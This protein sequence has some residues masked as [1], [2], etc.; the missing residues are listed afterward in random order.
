[1]NFLDL[2]PLQALTPGYLG[3]TLFAMATRMSSGHSGRPHAAA[4]DKA[5]LL[6]WALKLAILSSETSA[7]MPASSC[8]ILLF[9]IAM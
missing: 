1:M 6:Y 7:L 8:A 9:G 4:A 2:A 5:W 3:D